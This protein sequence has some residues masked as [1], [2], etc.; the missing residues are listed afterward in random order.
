MKSMRTW[1][2]PEL[3]PAAE[4]VQTH[5]TCLTKKAQFLPRSFQNNLIVAILFSCTL[6]PQSEEI[7]AEDEAEH[8][9][10]EAD[11]QD[12][13]VDV[14]RQVEELLGCH[15]AVEFGVLQSNVTQTPVTPFDRMH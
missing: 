4:L 7:A 1:A 8:E 12:D 3:F 6:S 5:G 2:N 9:D 14:E 10:K 13:D 15:L 11:A